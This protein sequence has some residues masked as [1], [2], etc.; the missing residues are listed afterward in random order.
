MSDL[1]LAAPPSPR[2]RG[3]RKNAILDAVSVVGLPLLSMGGLIL[4]WQILVPVLEVPRYILPVPSDFMT[5]VFTSRELLWEHTQVTGAE[6]LL[7]FGAAIVI[8]IPLA[9]IIASSQFIERAFYPLIVFF[10]LIPKIAIAPLFIVWFGFGIFPKVLITFFLC[11]FPI[12]VSSMIGF[13]SV[14]LRLLYITRS[15]GASRWQTFRFIRFPAALPFIFAGL[16]VSVVFATTG[17]I[18]G[19]FVGAQAG[20]GYLLLR[21]TSLLDMSLIFAV[22]VVLS[23]IGLALSYAVTITENLIMPW[24]SSKES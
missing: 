3:R 4:A 17:A 11:F 24:R 14:D 1:P 15:M 16:R 6:V 21:G 2:P 23:V 8:S 20:L 9:L 7:G 12:L 22:L 19:E 18:V 5:R 13:K 10:Q